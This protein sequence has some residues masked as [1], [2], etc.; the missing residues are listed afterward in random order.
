MQKKATTP[1]MV[2]HR[3]ELIKLIR[4]LS[5]KYSTWGVFTDFLAMA[6][7]SISNAVDWV[8]SSDREAQYMEIVGRY[9][10]REVALFPEMLA[11]LVMEMERHTERP[12]DVLGEIFHELELHNKYKGQFFTPQPV[13]DMMGLITLG[14]AA[15]LPECG[16]HTV[17]E[18]C[19][20]SGAMV[21]GF[22]NAMQTRKF[23]YHR[24][25][26]VTATDVDLKCVHMAYLQFSLYGIPA[27][28]IHGNSL[29]MQEW[30][31]WYTPVYMLDGWVWRQT[32][33]N[34]DKRYPEDEAMKRAEDPLYAAIRNTEA[35]LSA[36]ASRPPPSVAPAKPEYDFTLKESANGQLS[37]LFEGG[38]SHG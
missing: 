14:D 11:H 5:S 1:I 12:A 36:T 10:K 32:C 3:K 25:M 17:G 6:A 2:D 20:G 30:S 33:G 37:F 38:D 24:Q 7:I 19:V 9:E 22:V 15:D 35:L 29:T 27:V 16:Y 13:C 26:V 21:L 8:H 4:Q 31:R 28:V 18:P 34:D 23:D